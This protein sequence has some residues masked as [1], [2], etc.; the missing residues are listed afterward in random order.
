MFKKK[1]FLLLLLIGLLVFFVACGDDGDDPVNTDDEPG[2]EEPSDTGDDE[3]DGGEVGYT[4][5]PEMHYNYFVGATGT[6][7]DT[8]DTELGQKF[9]EETSGEKYVNIP[10]EKMQIIK[11]IEDAGFKNISTDSVPV[12]LID[13]K[14][15]WD[16]I[17]GKINKKVNKKGN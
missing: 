14:E 1:S 3:T 13:K 11:E 10:S 9:K 16:F 5:E 2:T 12:F 7:V 17:A 8:R 4:T 15:D 6:D